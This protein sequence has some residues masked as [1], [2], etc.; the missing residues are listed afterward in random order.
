MGIGPGLPDPQMALLSADSF[1]NSSGNV[2]DY[3]T[4]LLKVVST[5]QGWS[6]ASYVLSEV[7]NPTRTLRIAGPL[8]LGIV[9]ALYILTNVSYFLV[10]PLEDLKHSGVTVAATFT[11][12]IF[13][14]SGRR[15]AAG[16]AAI[17]SIGNI[18]TTTFTMSRVNQELAKEGMLPFPRFWASNWPC[19][20]PTAAMLLV[21]LSSF[22]V[23]MWVPFGE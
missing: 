2:Y 23:I 12:K 3:T 7:R 19:G 17:S 9:G 1:S 16:F 22:F 20:S 13:G 21:F 4:A 10:T 8:G 5:Y 15:I 11:G 18:M 6:N 14:S